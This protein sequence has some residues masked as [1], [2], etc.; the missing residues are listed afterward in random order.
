MQSKKTI[1]WFVIVIVVALLAYWYMQK[2]PLEKGN[3]SEMS[4]SDKLNAYAASEAKMKASAE[5]QF[6][7]VEQAQKDIDVAMEA[8]K[9]RDAAIAPKKT[10]LEKGFEAPNPGVNSPL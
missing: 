5:A 8:A 3:P 9:K 6:A 2:T 7:D 4:V 1:L 10:Q